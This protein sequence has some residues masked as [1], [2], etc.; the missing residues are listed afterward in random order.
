MCC[1]FTLCGTSRAFPLSRMFHTHPVQ[2]VQSPSV[3]RH[4]RPDAAQ[5][6]AA[7]DGK[8]AV[9]QSCI[10]ARHSHAPTCT[11][12]GCALVVQL[13]ARIARFTSLNVCVRKCVLAFWFRGGTDGVGACQVCAWGECGGET[14]DTT[15]GG[16]FAGTI[17]GSAGG[18]SNT[19]YACLPFQSSGLAPSYYG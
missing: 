5:L 6:C 12:M 11:R 3:G 8:D 7:E 2:N 10:P 14:Y 18:V 1:A 15:S 4:P 16:A 13:S 17:D 9:P 19:L